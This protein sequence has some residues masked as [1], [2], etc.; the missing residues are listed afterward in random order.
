MWVNGNRLISLRDRDHYL[1]ALRDIRE[2]LTAGKGPTSAGDLLVRIAAKVIRDVEPVL[3]ELDDE[4]D[5]LDGECDA[6]LNHDW[7]SGLGDLRRRALELRRYLAPQ[8]EA[9]GRLAHE[10]VSWMNR[11]DMVSL[12]E[13]TD[14]IVR[15]VENLD[16]VRERATLLNDH[17]TAQISERIAQTS[18]R[19]TALAAVLLPPSLIAS[20]FG[21]NVGGIPAGGHGQGFWIILGLMAVVM[22]SEIWLLRKLK[23]I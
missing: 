14:K 15:F 12:R 21:M 9:L 16:L 7:R 22:A 18:N 11:R 2:G 19:L 6:D 20:L 17:L 5:R 13:V 3:D 4:I 1:M 23:W 10:D 8:R